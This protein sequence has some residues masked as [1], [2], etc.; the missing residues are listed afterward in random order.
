MQIITI[1]IY[2]FIYVFIYFC[3][4]CVFFK[5]ACASAKGGYMHHLVSVR[6]C[7]Y[8]MTRSNIFVVH[9]K[10]TELSGTGYTFSMYNAIISCIF[11]VYYMVF[12]HACVCV[13]SS[14]AL[15]T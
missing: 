8:A 9:T 14:W 7:A 15:I 10:G 5:R 2:L 6:Y 1:F 12:C 4:K 13:V 11:H 3:V